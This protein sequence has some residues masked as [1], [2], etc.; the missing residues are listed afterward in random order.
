MGN[1]S[2][3]LGESKSSNLPKLLDEVYVRGVEGMYRIWYV[4]KG[5]VQIHHPD[6]RF[7]ELEKVT[8]KDF[9]LCG[10]NANPDYQVQQYTSAE[11][12][13]SDAGLAQARE[14]VAKWTKWF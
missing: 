2:R 13:A 1:I 4:P 11:F 6:P 3:E 8:T 12:E 14:W 5:Y 9:I 7:S 10:Y